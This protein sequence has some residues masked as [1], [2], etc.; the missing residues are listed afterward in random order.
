MRAVMREDTSAAS[1]RAEKSVI[2]CAA[3]QLQNRDVVMQREA[4]KA[5]K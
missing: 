5:T 1:R 3:N 2:Q 4:T